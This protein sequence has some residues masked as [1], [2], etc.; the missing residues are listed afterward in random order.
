MFLDRLLKFFAREQLKQ[1]GK[2]AAYSIHGGSLRG[3]K[4]VRREPDFQST[5]TSTVSEK[6][7]WTIVVQNLLPRY[8][9]RDDCGRSQQGRFP[10]CHHF[11]SARATRDGQG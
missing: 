2:N 11:H 1:L 6:L 8:N 7:I 3:L 10:G 9:A 4:L 5:G